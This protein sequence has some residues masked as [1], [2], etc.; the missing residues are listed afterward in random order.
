MMQYICSTP[1]R[2]ILVGFIPAYLFC[3]RTMEYRSELVCTTVIAPIL[4]LPPCLSVG[5]FGVWCI[6]SDH[7]LSHEAGLPV[8]HS[9]VCITMWGVAVSM[10]AFRC[11]DSVV[12]SRSS[13]SLLSTHLRQLP[14]RLNLRLG[15]PRFV[16]E[17]SLTV[18]LKWWMSS[19]FY[20][21]SLCQWLKK[22]TQI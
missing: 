11:M 13:I 4:H 5:L 3:L 21:P 22:A 2:F 7:R 12:P 15:S 10:W 6:C 20:S 16:S 1:P 8:C 14:Y 18:A 19:V 9:S 17:Y